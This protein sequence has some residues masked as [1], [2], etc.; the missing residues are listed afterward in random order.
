V[1]AF[2]ASSGSSRIPTNVAWLDGQQPE[3]SGFLDRP[4]TAAG[5]LHLTADHMTGCA[6]DRALDTEQHA[7]DIPR[8][9]T[10]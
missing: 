6:G 5:G 1:S 8:R 3:A 4:A 9:H 10:T 2:A 7:R